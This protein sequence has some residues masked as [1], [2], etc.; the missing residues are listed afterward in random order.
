MSSKPV[1]TLEEFLAWYFD[2]VVEGMNDVNPSLAL[3]EALD[4]YRPKRKRVTK[5]QFRPLVFLFEELRDRVELS[6][7]QFSE[8]PMSWCAH[9]DLA[10]GFIPD[11]LHQQGKAIVE[12]MGQSEAAA[13]LSLSRVGSDNANSSPEQEEISPDELV[14]LPISITDEGRRQ[15]AIKKE[16]F[17]RI[18][19]MVVSYDTPPS[20]TLTASGESIQI[21]G[22]PA[23]VITWME[24][25]KISVPPALHQMALDWEAA[26]KGQ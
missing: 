11:S 20:V 1:E 7:E 15:T 6:I 14:A 19:K 25:N 24:K 26:G 8:N 17:S 10:I 21:D 4:R 22:Y 23:Q 18:E 2:I 12:N 3:A 9:A 16:V 5:D 13:A